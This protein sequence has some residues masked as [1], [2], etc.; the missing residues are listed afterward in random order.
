MSKPLNRRLTTVDSSFLYFEKKE[1]PLHIGSVHLFEGEVPFDD[2]VAMMDAKMHLIPRYQQVVRF[3]PF[4]L[5]HPTW[6]YDSHFDLRKHIFKLQIDAPGGE[7]ELVELASKIFTPVMERDKPLWDIF[8][9]YGLEG[10]NSAM[11]A[12]IH[13]C[14]VD[15]MSGIDLIK[16]ILDISPNAGIPLKPETTRPRTERLDPTRQFFDSLLGGMEEG[17]NRWMEFQNGLLNLT[18]AF[19]E[20]P[21]RDAMTRVV[22]GGM[23]ISATPA[24]VLPFNQRQ[25]SGERRLVWS[26]FSF[27][28]VRQIR[29][30]LGGTV[31]DAALTILSG[32]VSKYVHAHGQPTEN[33]NVR[34]MV[35][36][37]LRQA[38][39][40]GALGNLVSILPVEIPLDLHDPAERFRFINQR[41]AQLK[42]GRV[43]E[44]VNLFSALMGVLPAPVQ[45]LAGALASMPMPAVNMVSTNVP[46]PQ[47]PLYTLGRKMLGYYPYVPVGYAVGCGCAILT[48]DQKITFGL[49]AD[50]QAM[51]DVERLRDFLNESFAEL[52]Q[53][54]HVEKND[55]PPIKKSAPRPV[56]EIKLSAAKETKSRTTRKTKPQAT[57]NANAKPPKTVKDKSRT[58]SKR[59]KQTNSFAVAR[60]KKPA[61]SAKKT[62]PTADAKQKTVGATG[63]K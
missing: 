16:I 52:L 26:E 62:K 50:V 28:E 38:D 44:G 55:A 29:A 56:K 6:E 37:S 58:T 8:W 3:D 11:I 9:V 59:A 14:M 27:A 4:N 15:G 57:T 45:A 61:A 1:A 31:N 7:Q 39:Q 32:A 51:P 63:A 23:P 12:R 2:F 53:A 17:M 48:Y 20:Q 49:T 33:R 13:H 5:A 60:E 43:A 10:G 46:G 54:A 35:P 19:V 18:Q 42:G 25:C 41:T 21:T 34:F 30:A 36:V 22:G 24:T 40:H 47:V